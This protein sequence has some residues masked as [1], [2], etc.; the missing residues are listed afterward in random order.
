[1]RLGRAITALAVLALMAV[2]STQAFA[3]GPQ[4]SP[5]TVPRNQPIQAFRFVGTIEVVGEDTITL[6]SDD[7]PE[8]GE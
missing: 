4:T 6:V 1:M 5:E 7:G 3:T 2:L 8:T